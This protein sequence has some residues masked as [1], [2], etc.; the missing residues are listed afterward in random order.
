MKAFFRVLSALAV[1]VGATS[2]ASA[3]SILVYSPSLNPTN[4]FG[5]PISA[6]GTTAAV[7]EPLS[8]LASYLVPGYSI[9]FNAVGSVC[10]NGCPPNSE[11]AVST[12]TNPIIGG[13]VGSGGI[14]GGFLGSFTLTGAQTTAVLNNW[15]ATVANTFIVTSAG[16]G[17]ITIPTGA[18]GVVFVFLDELYSDNND[19]SGTLNVNAS[20]SAPASTPEPAT[21][22]MMIAGLGAL[23]AFKRV[24]RS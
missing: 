12:I 23:L 20:F 18:T 4:T 9:S 8:A 24:R 22:G 13:F 16:T 17:P 6:G 11:V 3:N 1:M 21:Y 7:V 2:L 19:T 15:T 14:G 5:N 10:F